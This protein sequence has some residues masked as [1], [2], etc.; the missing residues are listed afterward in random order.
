MIDPVQIDDAEVLLSLTAIDGALIA[1]TTGRCFAIGAILDG[2]ALSKGNT[3]RGAR[4][5]SAITFV[6]YWRQKGNKV[7]AI[8]VSADDSVDI[9]PEDRNSDNDETIVELKDISSVM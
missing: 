3:A 2:E 5:N 4:Y 6:D 8:I 1:D 7:V 9:Y